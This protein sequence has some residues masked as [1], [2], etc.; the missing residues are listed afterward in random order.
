MLRKVTFQ[1]KA[2]ARRHPALLVVIFIGGIM[3]FAYAMHLFQQGLQPQS[4][5]QVAANK[6]DPSLEAAV[7]AIAAKFICACGNCGDKSL[8]VCT[9]P[10][11]SKEREMIRH[12]LKAGQRPEQIIATINDLYGGLKSEFN[13][14]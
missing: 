5:E 6:L 3:L 8:D 11:A 10:N 7:S 12:S 4:A 2:N 9:C 13:I 14:K 1:N